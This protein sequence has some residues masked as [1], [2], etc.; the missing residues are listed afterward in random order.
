MTNWLDVNAPFHPSY[1]GKKNAKYQGEA[2]YRPELPFADI[3]SRTVPQSLLE[4]QNVA[5]K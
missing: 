2:D 3:R 5:V 1:W 4:K